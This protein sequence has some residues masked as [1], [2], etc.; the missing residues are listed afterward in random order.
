MMRETR[1]SASVCTDSRRKSVRGGNRVGVLAAALCVIPLLALACDRGAAPNT[2]GTAARGAPALRG[3][4]MATVRWD[5]VFALGGDAQD[6]TLLIPRTLAARGGTLYVFDHGDA[7]LKAFDRTGGLRWSFGREGQGPGEFANPLDVE[8]GPDGAVWVLDAW[9]GRLTV[10]A[11]HGELQQQIPLHDIGGRDVMPLQGQTLVTGFS[12]PGWLFAAIG[13]DGRVLA[14]GETPIA[15]MADAPNPFLFQ[16]TAAVS[17]DGATWAATFPWGDRLLVYD[18]REL[19][20]E[21]RLV[22]AEPFPIHDSRPIPQLPIWAVDI[23]VG[24]S[25][26]F[27]LARGRTS[28]AL[29][30]L[31]E[32]DARDCRY[33]RTL[34]LPREA[35]ALAYADGVFYIEHEDPSP[36]ILALRPV[37]E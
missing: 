8:V 34:L 36:Q 29:R 2:G 16:T 3:R 37:F 18:H 12:R 13:A 33:R 11:P 30:L 15:E 20:C 27:V 26:V 35:R 19:R 23:A 17:A 10:V 21:G 32:Y 9:A 14:G 1:G 31:D 7:R 24:D 22:E 6:T 4:V 25:S 28:A 5:T